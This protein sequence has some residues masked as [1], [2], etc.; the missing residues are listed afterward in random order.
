M[1]INLFDCKRNTWVV[2]VEE[3]TAPPA[4][5]KVEVGEPVKFHNIDGMYSYC[6]DLDGNIVHLPAWQ[7]VRVLDY[8]PTK[9]L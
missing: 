9:V 3:T 2:P 7:K 6:T 8:D 1:I 4:A 5:R